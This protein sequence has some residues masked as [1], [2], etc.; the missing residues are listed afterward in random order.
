MWRGTQHRPEMLAVQQIPN[1]VESQNLPKP[2]EPIKATGTYSST[3][4]LHNGKEKQQETGFTNPQH[5]S[6]KDD[7]KK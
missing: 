4:Q 3:N 2:Q 5:S 1:K 7:E 6:I